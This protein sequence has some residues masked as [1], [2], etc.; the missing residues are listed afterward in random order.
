MMASDDDGQELLWLWI[1]I[2]V[3]GFI[4]M[5]VGLVFLI[6]EQRRRLRRGR[7]NNGYQSSPTPIRRL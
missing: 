4:G 1:T 5:M 6:R 2:G 7:Y 3:I